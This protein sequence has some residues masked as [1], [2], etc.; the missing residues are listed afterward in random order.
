MP[1][2]PMMMFVALLFDLMR[3]F[4]VFSNLSLGHRKSK[5]LWFQGE[6]FKIFL[7]L[8]WKLPFALL[9]TKENFLSLMLKKV[10]LIFNGLLA[11]R[12]NFV[13]KI[14]ILDG[15]LSTALGKQFNQCAA[16]GHGGTTIRTGLWFRGILFPGS[17]FTATAIHRFGF[18]L[19]RN[20]GDIA[21]V[22]IWSLLFFFYLRGLIVFAVI[23]MH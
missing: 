15:I 9:T 16:F 3:G 19:G 4:G 23:F 17:I 14:I 12:A 11:Y 8:F 7:R 2:G 6:F 10:F 21:P 20:F 13:G 18:T 1:P 22:R 5:S